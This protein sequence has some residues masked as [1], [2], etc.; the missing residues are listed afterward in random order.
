MGAGEAPA[1]TLAR[2]AWLAA[3][4]GRP[5][6]PHNASRADRG[7]LPAAGAAVDELLLLRLLLRKLLKLV[8]QLL[9]HSICAAD[10]PA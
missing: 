9:L 1:T 10:D 5:E 7:L 6:H 8:L 3:L 2:A 4:R